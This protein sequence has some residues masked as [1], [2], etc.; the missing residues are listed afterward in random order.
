MLKVTA[1]PKATAATNL[2][3][4]IERPIALFIEKALIPADEFELRGVLITWL[5]AAVAAE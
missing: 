2:G 5:A 3:I 1:P 4:P